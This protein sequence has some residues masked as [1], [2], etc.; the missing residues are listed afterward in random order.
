MITNATIIKI[1]RLAKYAILDLDNGYSIIWHFGMS[2]KVKF[3]ANNIDD[4]DK[5]DHVIIYTDKGIVIY[6]DIRRF[7]LM[8]RLNRW[9][10]QLKQPASMIK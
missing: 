7:G 2:G 6:N 10:P 4:F 3:L 5:H 8:I 1:W 9:K